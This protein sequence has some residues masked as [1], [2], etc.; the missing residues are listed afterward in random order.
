MIQ[1]KIIDSFISNED[2]EFKEKTFSQNYKSQWNFVVEDAVWESW[3]FSSD[4][5]NNMLKY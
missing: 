5:I 3:M 2:T 1:I 4:L